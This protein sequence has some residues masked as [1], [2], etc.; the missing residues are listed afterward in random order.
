MCSK[1]FAKTTGTVDA[2]LKKENKFSRLVKN[3][4]DAKNQL[5]H[6]ESIR[7]YNPN[8]KGKR[9]MF[10][11]NSIT[12]HGVKEDIGWKNEWGM[13]ASQ[14]EKDYVH[15]V[16]SDVQKKEPDA[17]FCIC[18]V[19]NWEVNYKNGSKVHDLYE[20]ARDFE[21]DIIIM[22]FVENCR[23]DGFDEHVFKVELNKFINYLNPQNKAQI[24]FTTS[25]WRHPG[26]D[27]I[28]QIAAQRGCALV[29]LG[30]LGENDEMMAKGLFW[31]EGVA[32]HPGDKGMEVI[33]KRILEYI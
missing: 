19:A 2:S 25:F 11:G 20:V 28:R 21:A 1:S 7:F 12:L 18:Q 33:A 26:D 9:I 32:M 23:A 16:M 15:L 27:A 6:G 13:A 8:G 3:N 14:K 5:K 29:E 24:I 31:H 30:D 17:S 10:A 4:V 22:R